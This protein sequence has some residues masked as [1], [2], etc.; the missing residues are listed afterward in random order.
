MVGS[1]SVENKKRMIGK[2]KKKQRS[3][4]SQPRGGRGSSL[5]R[6]EDDTCDWQPGVGKE[7]QLWVYY[8]PKD[9]NSR[10]DRI[11]AKKEVFARAGAQGMTRLELGTEKAYRLEY[12][13]RGAKK[14]R[15]RKKK[16]GELQVKAV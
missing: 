16:K 5:V 4:V 14:R 9:I 12:V 2:V 8:R 6:W 11:G 10:R 13:G 1:K 15:A 3:V 7:S